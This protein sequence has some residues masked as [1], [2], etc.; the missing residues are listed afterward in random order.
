M[1]LIPNTPIGKREARG[2]VDYADG[3]GEFTSWQE[4]EF[5]PDAVAL[6]REIREARVQAKVGLRDAATHLG[7]AVVE[8]S[9]LERGR[10]RL[11]VEDHAMALR[12]IA[13][14]GAK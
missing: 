6:G 4:D 3:T 13:K 7:I 9:S 12:T 5:S 10:A 2:F 14:A 11:S 8:L 1:K